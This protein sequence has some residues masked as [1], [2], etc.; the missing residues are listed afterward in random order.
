MASDFV[1]NRAKKQRQ[2]ENKVYKP[3]T[4]DRSYINGKYGDETNITYK[5]VEK[6]SSTEPKSEYHVTTGR[7]S[8]FVRQRA[9]K[10]R[11]NRIE[12]YGTASYGQQDNEP[13]VQRVNKSS[14][15]DTAIDMLRNRNKQLFMNN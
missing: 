2:K 15:Q 4:I 5:T 1:K 10:Q 11:Q 9:E 14:V 8:D 6:P 3:A 7:A 13:L 12:N